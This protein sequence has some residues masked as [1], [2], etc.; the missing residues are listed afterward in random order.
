LNDANVAMNVCNAT[1]SG[2]PS[3]SGFGLPP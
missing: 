1:I 2:V 3:W